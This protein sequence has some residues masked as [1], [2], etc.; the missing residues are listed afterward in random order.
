VCTVMRQTASN[1]H[2]MHVEHHY[3]FTTDTD[4]RVY[5]LQY[6]ALEHGLRKHEQLPTVPETRRKR[7]FRGDSQEHVVDYQSLVLPRLQTCNTLWLR[8]INVD[9][10]S[11]ITGVEG[12]TAV[13]L[14]DSAEQNQITIRYKQEQT[15]TKQTYMCDLHVKGR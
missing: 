15:T 13:T 1:A 9:L 3:S 5:V 8:M 7:L 2:R 4:N 10:H 6:A 14:L 12:S 11:E